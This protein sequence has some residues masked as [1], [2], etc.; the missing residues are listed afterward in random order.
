M[1]PAGS[2][3]LFLAEDSTGATPNVRERTRLASF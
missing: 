2:N 1:R 3:L